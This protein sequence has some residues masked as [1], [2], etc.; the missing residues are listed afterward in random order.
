MAR[1]KRFN[2]GNVDGKD[3]KSNVVDLPALSQPEQRVVLK[4]ELHRT[5]GMMGLD[6]MRITTNQR[7]SPRWIRINGFHLKDQADLEDLVF[8]T[9]DNYDWSGITM[10]DLRNKYYKASRA[11]TNLEYCARLCMH[12]SGCDMFEYDHA[13]KDCSFYP[14]LAL[15]SRMFPD[16]TT[17]EADPAVDVAV[18]VLRC[19]TSQENVLDGNEFITQDVR[20]RRKN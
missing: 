2:N 9:L 19:S 7:C 5:L 4:G 17:V 14:H 3:W 13:T 1:A 8:P 18:Y 10:T 12:G 20:R 15:K 6:I 11:A 16:V